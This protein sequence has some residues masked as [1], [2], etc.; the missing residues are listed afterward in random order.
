[1]S[2][3]SLNR[4]KNT[5]RWMPGAD[6]PATLSEVFAQSPADGGAVGFVM[7]QLTRARL[8][9]FWVQDRL[10]AKEAGVP[11]LPGVG[12][13]F[14]MVHLS[15]PD[16]VLAAM[17]EGLRA[18][19][20]AAVVGEVWGAP[21]SLDFTATRRLV[22][23]AEAMGVACWLIRRGATPD[24]SA[25]RN[26]WRVASLPSALHAHDP[27][28]PG[29]ARWRVDLFR[30][31]FADPG[32]WVARYDRAADRVDFTAAVPDRVLAEA[33]RTSGGIAGA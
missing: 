25:A 26:R 18:G 27:L 12:R 7:S 20:L 11:Y 31:R 2:V 14:V 32:T 8:P 10:S 22:L 16:E 19:G 3:I 24:L 33:A 1:M 17:E 23:R 4:P 21:S 13:P 5:A 30:S 15:R 28:A 9:I 6:L 29:D